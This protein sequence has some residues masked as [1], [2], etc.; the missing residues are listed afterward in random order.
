VNKK[1][2]AKQM[3]F[4]KHWFQCFN[5]TE[6][7]KRAGYSDKCAHDAGSRLLRDPLIKKEMDKIYQER[8]EQSHTDSKY[9]LEKLLSVVDADW[10]KYVIMGRA[11]VEDIDAIPE[12]IRKMITAI[13]RTEVTTGIGES[14]E[15][16]V[17]YKFKLMDKTKCLELL[18]KTHGLFNDKLDVTHG[19]DKSFTD[20]LERVS[21]IKPKK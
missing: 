11:G 18:G 4:I 2:N 13:D 21:K 8:R 19:V 12:H 17:T 10:S 16:R 3:E 15:R 1:P 5:A 7:A 20:M 6:S 9:V 14:R